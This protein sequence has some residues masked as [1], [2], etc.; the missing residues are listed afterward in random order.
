VNRRSFPRHAC[1]RTFVTLVTLTLGLVTTQTAAGAALAGE[2]PGTASGTATPSLTAPTGVSDQDTGTDG[3]KWTAPEWRPLNTCRG[4]FGGDAGGSLVKT[5][6]AGP[7][8][9]IVSPGQ[10]ITVTLKWNPSDFSG[11]RPFLVED[12]V[13]IGRHNSAALSQVHIPGPSGGTDTFSYV[14]PAGGTGG[15]PICDRAV[16]AGLFD[17]RTGWGDGGS[18]NSG[19]DDKS[20]GEG[21]GPGATWGSGRREP[22]K[23]AIFCYSILDPAAPEVTNVLLLPAAGF[24]VAGVVLLIV[25]RRQ[26]DA[27]EL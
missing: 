19:A 26:N 12:C 11:N 6:S 3:G 5:T 15:H 23:S 27:V 7:S 2:H 16:A 20:Q 17:P 14:V 13:K 22:E 21:S 24:L 4:V 25:R 18:G 9:G 1:S 8:G 10:T